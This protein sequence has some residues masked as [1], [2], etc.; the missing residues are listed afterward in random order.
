MTAREYIDAITREENRGAEHAQNGLACCPPTIDVN[1]YDQASYSQ[2]MC[3]RSA[4]YRGFGT[5]VREQEGGN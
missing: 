1:G 5:S 2:W 3:I 4:Y